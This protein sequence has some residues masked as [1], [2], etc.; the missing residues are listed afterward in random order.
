[1]FKQ[2]I[3][4]WILFFYIYCFIG[5]VWE[6]AYVSIKKWK[7]TNRGFM[8][9]PFLPI[10][11]FGALAI[12][13]ATIPVKDS[14]PLT[15]LVGMLAATILEYITGEAMEALFKVRYWD[16]SNQKFNLNGH[17]CLT[18]SIAWGV[19]SI[20]MVNVIHVPIAD[21]VNNI[22]RLLQEIIAVLLSI[23]VSVDM[24][25]SVRD[26]L[27][28]KEMLIN[29]KQNNEEIQKLQKRLDVVIAVLDDET[30]NIRNKIEQL[31]DTRQD[32]E[33]NSSGRALESI[34]KR[35]DVVE[36]FTAQIEWKGKD[37]QHLDA[38]L[39]FERLKEKLLVSITKMELRK[40]KFL[41]RPHKML[42]RNP[43]AVSKKYQN[44]LDEMKILRK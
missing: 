18:S 44:E 13:V 12:L 20:L 32:D 5:W 41:E 14:K 9:G 31:V 43:T 19:A 25:T 15:F 17:I 8:K 2:S 36:K 29:L 35:F 10:Y 27:D 37:K 21:F 40:T 6:T 42:R 38:K 7:Y 33:S 23:G 1:M 11:G 28:I 16:Y 34:R 22:P 30:K 4:Q 3:I 24:A 26:A 39:E